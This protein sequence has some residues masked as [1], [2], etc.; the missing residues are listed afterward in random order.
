[1]EPLRRSTHA[2]ASIAGINT[3]S[4]SDSASIQHCSPPSESPQSRLSMPK[5]SIVIPCYNERDTVATLIN[6]VRG[7]PIQ[8][9]TEIIVVNDCSTD[10]THA[11]LDEQIAPLVARVI[12]H[13]VNQGKGAALRTGFAAATGDFVIIQDADMEYSP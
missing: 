6:T 4:R 3:S 11:V 10:G 9:E 2:T 1:E 12:H 13:Q 8:I 7:A 5:L